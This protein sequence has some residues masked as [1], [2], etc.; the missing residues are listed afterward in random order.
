MPPQIHTEKPLSLAITSCFKVGLLVLNDMALCNKF[1]E[2]Y[3]YGKLLREKRRCFG[4][5][6][7]SKV[8]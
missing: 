5:A 3:E 8:L 6:N 7:L 4:K 1:Y 2:I